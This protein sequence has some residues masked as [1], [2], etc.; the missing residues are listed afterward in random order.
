M[1]SRVFVSCGQHT[2][3][4]L[5]IAKRIVDLFKR[6]GFDPYVAKHVQSVF[7]I[8]SGIVGELKNSDCYLF[9]NFRREPIG[10]DLYRGSLFSNQEFAIAY[11][12]GFDRIIVVNEK[13]VS[14]EGM[15]RYI[16]C[17]TESFEDGE[18][19]L[20]IV[21][22]ALDQSN[23]QPTYSRRLWGQNIRFETC[24]YR[25]FTSE[26]MTGRFL[27]L[28][29][30]NNRPDIAGVETTGRL[31]G[32]RPQGS[33]GWVSPS[34]LHSSPLKAAGRSSYSHTIFPGSFGK[35]NMLFMGTVSDGAAHRNGVYLNSALDLVPNPALPLDAGEWALL[36]EFCAIGFPLHRVEV[37]LSYNTF[38]DATAEVLRQY[39]AGSS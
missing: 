37:S 13:G 27:S 21:E 24:T 26:L 4:E 36:Y 12:L 2:D 9:I 30:A 23:W 31:A 5:D 33:Q 17:N 29:I 7:E 10:E 3:R 20:R 6:R 22:N 11:A 34:T 19:C 39:T 35:F 8:N 25:H 32:F 15:L 38:D 28:D 16:G 18:G 1:K 14:S